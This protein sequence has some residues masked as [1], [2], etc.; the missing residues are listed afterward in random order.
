MS[1]TV[2]S[3][4]PDYAIHPGEYLEEVLESREISQRDL[5]SRMGVKE[6]YLSSIIHKNKSIGPDTALKL[7][8]VLGISSNI[9]NNMNAN[10]KLFEAKLK[11]YAELANKKEWAREFPL[12]WLKKYKYIPDARNIEELI[13]PLLNFFG[14][15]S[16]SVWEQYYK[17]TQAV[18]RNSSSFIS[19]QKASTTWLRAGII[20][21]EKITT[22][23]YNKNTFKQNLN[24]ISKLTTQNS[25]V[26]MK[27]IVDLCAEAGVAFVCVPL[28]PKV[29]VYAAT[30]WLNPKKAMICLSLRYKSND[31]FWFSFFHEAAH[32]LYHRKKNVYIHDKSTKKDENEIEAN[33]AARQML[34][35]ITEYNHF[36]KKGKFY[37]SDIIAFSKK[38]KIAPGI[39]VGAL[40]HD[41]KIEQGWHYELKEKIDFTCYSK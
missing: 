18:Y 23:P 34:L 8:K 32:I 33:K 14:I 15:T 28:P 12:S 25:S 22:T 3:F 11:E 36:V 35:P 2:N 17:K 10:F 38:Y 7:E 16:P 30:K 37:K 4:N 1:T 40:Q 39:I 21:A 20:K 6:D 31:Q 13:K 27:K 19:E 41:K 9:W 26:F 29:H 5:A 24:K